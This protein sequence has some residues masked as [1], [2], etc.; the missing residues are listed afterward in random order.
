MKKL[1]LF[2]CVTLLCLAIAGV[3]QA[4]EVIT[5]YFYPE[6]NSSYFIYNGPGS[7]PIARVNVKFERGSSGDRLER[8]SPIPLIGSIK[9]LPYSGTSAYVLDITDYSVTARSWWSEDT[10]DVQNSRGVL[11]S[12]LVFLKLPAKDETLTWTTNVNENGVIKQIWEMSARLTAIPAVENG[13][14]IA[15]KA[16]EIRRTVFDAQHNPLPGLSVTEY[17]Q[18]G[19]GKVKVVRSK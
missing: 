10:Q 1:K 4:Q 6:G 19:K 12:N 9:S 5:D 16:L 2:L 3:A 7:Q 11:R 8:E 14:R 13:E 17:W 18:K 15:A